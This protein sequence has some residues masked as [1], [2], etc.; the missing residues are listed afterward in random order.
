MRMP[1]L[2][3]LER[4]SEAAVLAVAA[5]RQAAVFAGIAEFC[6]PDESAAASAGF[7]RRCPKGQI[8]D[9]TFEKRTC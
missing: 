4:L 3:V 8:T 2:V 9:N 5:G 6:V 7:S 1:L